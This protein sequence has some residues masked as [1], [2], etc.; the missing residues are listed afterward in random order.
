MQ[1]WS[2]SNLPERIAIGRSSNNDVV[3]ADSVVSRWHAEVVR[4]GS[5]WIFVVLGI[6]GAY[7]DGQRVDSFLLGD[8][9]CVQLGQTGPHLRFVGTALRANSEI[10]PQPQ[11]RRAESNALA[12]L[13]VLRD[14]IDRAIGES[15]A[16]V[17]R[18]QLVALGSS[19][20]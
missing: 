17:S 2:F 6:N 14:N 11:N 5:D 7:V 13:D 20:C 9:V 10:V 1:C 18:A 12:E 15:E 4:L 3:L 16:A 8:G 19:Y